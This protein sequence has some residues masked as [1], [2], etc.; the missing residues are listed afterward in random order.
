MNFKIFPFVTNLKRKL[1]YKLVKESHIADFHRK[2]GVAYPEI[3]IHRVCN[4]TIL[5]K[6]YNG[7][8]HG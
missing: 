8:G 3:S 5:S 2:Q 1:T 6:H 4:D 7:V